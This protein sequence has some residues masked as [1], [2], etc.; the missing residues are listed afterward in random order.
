MRKQTRRAKI[1]KLPASATNGLVTTICVRITGNDLAQQHSEVAD[2]WIGLDKVD[3][4][5]EHLDAEVLNRLCDW[6][7]IFIK[8][9][10]KIIHFY[11]GL[12]EFWPCMSMDWDRISKVSEFQNSS[13]EIKAKITDKMQVLANATPL[14]KLLI[15]K[16]LEKGQMVAV[17][18]SPIKDSPLL[19][20]A[21]VGFSLIS[22]M[23]IALNI[24]AFIINLIASLSFSDDQVPLEPFKLLWVN[25]ITDVLVAFALAVPS[26]SYSKSLPVL[27]TTIGTKKI[28][29]RNV[30][31]G[32]TKPES[33]MFVVM[34]V[35]IVILHMAAIEIT[36]F[37]NQKE[38]VLDVQNCVSLYWIISLVSANWMPCKVDSI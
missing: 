36:I 38:K 13:T 30:F 12:S 5:R 2:L 37:V 20:E 4:S 19:K 28:D 6:L 25:I 10:L 22:N 35:A 23:E 33:R 27:K 24:A 18:G 14:D 16:C 15:V 1:R 7:W 17:S 11:A 26:E 8:N 3:V 29:K 34:V 31:E 21:D 32:I 9:L